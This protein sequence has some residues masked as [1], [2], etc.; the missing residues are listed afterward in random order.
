MYTGILLKLYEKDHTPRKFE[1]VKRDYN[2]MNVGT[3][4]TPPTKR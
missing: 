4:T 2:F 1:M 3:T